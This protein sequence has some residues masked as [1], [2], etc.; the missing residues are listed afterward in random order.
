MSGEERPPASSA[1]HPLVERF[2]EDAHTTEGAL[3]YFTARAIQALVTG[4]AW[5]GA[6]FLHTAKGAR[7]ERHTTPPTLQGFPGILWQSQDGQA[8]VICDEEREREAESEVSGGSET[9]D[10]TDIDGQKEG[11]G[12]DAVCAVEVHFVHKNHGEYMSVYVLAHARGQ[13][14]FPAIVERVG[15]PV[16]TVDDCRITEYL[17]KKGIPY[18]TFG[19]SG[20]HGWPEYRLVEAF[21]G[22]KVTRRTGVHLMNHIDEGVFVMASRYAS[23][24]S[25]RAFCLHP[26]VQGDA[27][28]AAFV[29]QGTTAQVDKYVLLLALEYRNIANG[30]PPHH[31]HRPLSVS[32]SF[33]PNAL[34]LALDLS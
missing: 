32:L 6:H 22:D 16:I 18:K 34:S 15:L 30:I 12:E 13:G 19:R 8:E 5:E 17:E 14:L 29:E 28:L 10:V 4:W 1:P 33:S 21:Y 7:V 26:L 3:Q 20:S 2:P 23:E 27:D 25:M 9:E 24:A 11:D 31:L